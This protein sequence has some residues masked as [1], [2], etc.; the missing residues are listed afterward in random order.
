MSK[1]R[2]GRRRTGRTLVITPTIPDDASPELKDALAIRNA[3]TA[4]GR[5]PSCGAVAKIVTP[6]TPGGAG[7]AWMAHEDG[8]PALLGG[9]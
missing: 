7:E 6:P 8:C 9:D 1:A 5:C 3:A 2:R 4:T